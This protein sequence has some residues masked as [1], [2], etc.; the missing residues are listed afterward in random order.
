MTTVTIREETCPD[1][2]DGIEHGDK[3]I[4]HRRRCQQPV[5]IRYAL[6]D[7]LILHTNRTYESAAHSHKQR[8]GDTLAADITYDQR[9]VVIVDT[10]EIVE[11][12]A[13][14]LGCLHR[15]TDIEFVTDIREGREFARQDKL[16][17]LVGRGF[18]S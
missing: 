2:V 14:V 18:S 9:N 10:D 5:D 12:A 7:M 13:D 8:C 6:A 11:V 17:D 1:V 3:H 16:L 15:G 4:L